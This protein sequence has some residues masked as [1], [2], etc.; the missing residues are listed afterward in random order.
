[1]I[2]RLLAAWVLGVPLVLSGCAAA[3]KTNS[4]PRAHCRTLGAWMQLQ[5]DPAHTGWT[6]RSCITAPNV[7]L[8]R[9][10]WR[11]PVHTESGDAVVGVR[12]P[13]GGRYIFTTIDERGRCA[14]LVARDRDTGRMVWKRKLAASW[15]GGANYFANEVDVLERSPTILTGWDAYDG[16][17]AFAKRLSPGRWSLP[18]LWQAFLYLIGPRGQ[19]AVMNESDGAELR[20]TVPVSPSHSPVRLADLTPVVSGS[21]GRTD[22]A[23]YV[24]DGSGNIYA[25]DPQGLKFRWRMSTGV[26]ARTIDARLAVVGSTLF[27]DSNPKIFCAVDVQTRRVLWRSSAARFRLDFATDGGRVYVI[28]QRPGRREAQPSL[29]ALDART[30]KVAWTF[31]SRFGLEEPAVAN[32]VVFV[33]NRGS[34]PASRFFALAAGTGRKLWSSVGA[35]GHPPYP[36]ITG[37]RVFLGSQAYGL[38]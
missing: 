11:R 34:G 28:G 21:L 36:A 35:G 5:H 19:L 29:I 32:G 8:L 26:P 16:A 3:A 10:L 24:T 22:N 33:S 9:L 38:P 18:T 12:D 30:G 25:F 17:R 6:T 23:V 20:K 13:A 7:H 27:V 14:G 1:M 15:C 4:S 31:T 37:N 2:T